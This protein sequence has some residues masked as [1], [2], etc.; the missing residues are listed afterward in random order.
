MEFKAWNFRAQSSVH[1]NFQYFCQW[2]YLTHC[3]P[4]GAVGPNAE[5]PHSMYKPNVKTLAIPPLLDMSCILSITMRKGTHTVVHIGL[6]KVKVH[7]HVHDVVNYS[8][9]ADLILLKNALIMILTCSS[10]CIF[11]P[12]DCHLCLP[13]WE[14][15]LSVKY[16]NWNL[17]T[18]CYTWLTAHFK[19]LLTM[20]TE[21][22]VVWSHA[23]HVIMI[24]VPANGHLPHLTYTWC[25]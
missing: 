25:L 1:I 7:D 3:A 18:A 8:C 15:L 13:F 2:L 9:H 17:L 12:C 14:F 19:V 11:C 6:Q 21:T 20:I 22:C 23:W 5:P 10:L 16:L 24:C 4:F